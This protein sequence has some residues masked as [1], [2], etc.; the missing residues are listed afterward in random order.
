MN[1]YLGSCFIH[2][3]LTVE[4]MATESIAYTFFDSFFFMLD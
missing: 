2:P 1:K 4:Y 3:D